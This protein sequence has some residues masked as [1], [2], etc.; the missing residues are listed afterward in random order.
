MSA[1]PPPDGRTAATSTVPSSTATTPPPFDPWAEQVRRQAVHHAQRQRRRRKRAVPVIV[2]AVLVAG[3]TT[4]SVVL[5]RRS[6]DR[7][8]DAST[9]PDVASTPADAMA[10][11]ASGSSGPEPTVAPDEL[12]EVDQVW[13]VDR[14]DGTFDWGVSVR[15]PTI[16]SRRSGVVID[17][18]LTDADGAIVHEASG[19]VDG[20]GPESTGA[21]AG[22][23]TAPVSDPVRIEFDVA[24]GVASN[25]PGIGELLTVRA[26]E[27]TGERVTGRIASLATEPIED[28]TMV[29]LWFDDAGE[30]VAA[31]PQPVDRVRPEVEARFDI[32]LSRESVPEG[33]PD[34]VVWTR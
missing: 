33:G 8:D 11:T 23:L 3:A 5:D 28:V 22:R 26:I 1:I 10:S 13:L 20:I 9:P 7:P 16:A 34:S 14:G 31:V 12:V 2:L 29:L 6:G 32:D 17:V 19:E 21:V 4:A 30:V 25:D 24:V 18:W 27:R 15:T